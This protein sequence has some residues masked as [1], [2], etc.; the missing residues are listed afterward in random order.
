M[1]TILL[2]GATGMQG[3]AVARQLQEGG[4]AIISPVRSTEKVSQLADL[5]IEGVVSDFSLDSLAQIAQKATKA[6]VLVPAVIPTKQMVPFTEH[7]IRA[8]KQAGIERALLNISSVIPDEEVGIAGPDTRLRM[9]KVAFEILPSINVTSSTLYLENF[10]TAYR[11]AILEQGSIP[12]AIP[13]D[14]PVA[15]MSMEDLGKYIAAILEDESISGQ[16][17]PIGGKQAI[18]GKEVA[19][20]LSEVTGKTV[21]YFALQPE[22]L[23]GFLTPMIGESLAAQVGEMYAWEGTKGKAKLHPET[24]SLI[25]RLGIEI[26]NFRQ[27]AEGVF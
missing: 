21:Q 7:A 19:T 8:I 11:Q 6:V 23:I 9:K 4:H 10:S 26:P 22:Q 5:G 13:E 3:A 16:Y 15:Y 14:V 24:A 17:I 20:I 2:F 1:S 27:W 12:Q 18:T 25:Q